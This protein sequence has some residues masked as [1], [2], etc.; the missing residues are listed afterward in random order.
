MSDD[1]KIWKVDLSTNHFSWLTS[2]HEMPRHAMM[3]ASVDGRSEEGVKGQRR[4]CCNKRI[5][6]ASATSGYRHF[7]LA[8][9]AVI[10]FLLT[11]D[12]T[13]VKGQPSAAPARPTYRFPSSTNLPNVEAPTPVFTSF[14]TAN[15]NYNYNYNYNNNR[16]T[17]YNNNNSSSNVPLK[18]PPVLK[19]GLII[20]YRGDFGI[21]RTDVQ[22][23]ITIAEQKILDTK[24]LLPGLRD[25]S[26]NMK[27]SECSE[28]QGP[29][30]AI[31]MVYTDT[32]HVFM[33]P[34]CD[35]SLGHVTGYC[36]V[37]DIP[38]ITPGGGSQ[39][40]DNKVE[41]KM[42]TRMQGRYSMLWRLLHSVM[43][44]FQWE[45]IKF[46]YHDTGMGTSRC[47]HTAYPMYLGAQKYPGIT[48]YAET[49]NEN[50][51]RQPYEK[52][53]TEA[54]LNARIIVLCASTEAVREIMIKAHE[55]NFDNGEYV[56]FNI[57][58]FSSDNATSMPWY[59]ASDTPERNEKAKKAYEALM[60]VTLRK[61]TSPEYRKFSRE[62]KARAS[63][64][65]KNFTYGE[66]EVNS[67]VGAFHD[68]VIL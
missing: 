46:L 38:I 24:F 48:P 52:V 5:F 44:K 36:N 25:I 60:T 32:V 20:S 29:Y 31:E 19:I 12:V 54:S 50:R 18:W 67:F 4:R 45:H 13:A 14:S 59:N 43:K 53:L 63:T 9:L 37:W 22:A 8:C 64:M 41:Y 61:P 28:T 3:E 30:N 2:S 33:G 62:V 10:L 1:S 65:Y 56:F 57:D 21:S 23:A 39:S 47:Y 49:F 15:N 27:D 34:V 66:Q 26:V 58:L 7:V 17:N 16:I 51:L 42:L 6:L 35:Y 55:L 11:F 40:L 68:A